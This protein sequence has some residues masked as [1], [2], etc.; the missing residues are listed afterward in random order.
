MNNNVELNLRDVCVPDDL[1]N[2]R[3]DLVIIS[4]LYP[5]AFG[6][7][8]NEIKSEVE[9]YYC[10]SSAIDDNN[11][12]KITMEVL[13]E[14]AFIWNTCDGANTEKEDNFNDIFA[15]IEIVQEEE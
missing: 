2:H 5:V 15:Y 13:N 9:E 3:G 14:F 4:F 6:F 8:K 10:D 11:L 7:L 12:D 1:Q